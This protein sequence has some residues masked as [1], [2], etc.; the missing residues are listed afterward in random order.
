M[1]VNKKVII[2]VFVV[3]GIGVMKAVTK[4]EPITPVILG[5]YVFLLV[6]SVADL[7]GGQISNVVGGLA[8]VAVLT[9]ILY[10][11]P[12]STLQ[13][14]LT[15]PA[16][17]PENTLPQTGKGTLPPSTQNPSGPAH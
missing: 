12:W 5:S 4:Q 9:S 10:D 11:F 14:L 6:L 8:M 17:Q 1:E 13:A 16:G 15:K 2:A 7:A 3:G